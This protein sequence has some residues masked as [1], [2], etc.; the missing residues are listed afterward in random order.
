MSYLFD[1]VRSDGTSARVE[2]V[3]QA[4]KVAMAD[5]GDL[6]VYVSWC[7]ASVNRRRHTSDWVLANAWPGENSLTVS[8]VVDVDPGATPVEVFSGPI[9]V[10]DIDPELVSVAASAPVPP[11]GG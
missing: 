8:R 11:E 3:P 1:I 5:D 4:F 10:V 2:H 7:A 6:R 9:L